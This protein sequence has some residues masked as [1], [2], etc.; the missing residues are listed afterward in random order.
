[1]VCDVSRW[2]KNGCVEHFVTAFG[3]VKLRTAC[4]ILHPTVVPIF[5]A[6]AVNMRC[7]WTSKKRRSEKIVYCKRGLGCLKSITGEIH[8][9]KPFY[10]FGSLRIIVMTDFFNVTTYFTSGS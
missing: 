3:I 9:M 10:G 4:A 2:R 1:M 7:G 6:I 8:I 5:I